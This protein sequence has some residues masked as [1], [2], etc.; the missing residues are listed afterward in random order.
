MSF[1]SVIY[2]SHI[3]IDILFIDSASIRRNEYTFICWPM[4]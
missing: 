1:F 2:F 3:V 4:G